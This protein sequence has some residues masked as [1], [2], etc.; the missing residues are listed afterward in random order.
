MRS[1][2]KLLD[3]MERVCIIATVGMMGFMTFINIVQIIFRYLFSD[4]F[5]WIFPLTMLLFI[6]MTFLGAFVVY[7]RKK[8]IIVSFFVDRFPKGGQNILLVITNIL[9]MAFLIGVL[10]EIPKILQLQAGVMEVISLPRYVKAI[11][12]FMA[13]TGIFLNYFV[14]TIDLIKNN[15]LSTTH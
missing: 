3:L 4:E 15:Y 13:T 5:V 12:L 9:A 6:W 10:G 14:D 11:P 7:R 8:V 1:L 2:K